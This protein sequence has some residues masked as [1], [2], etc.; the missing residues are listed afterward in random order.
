MKFSHQPVLLQETIEKLNLKPH[1]LY[2]DCT[3]GAAGH[4]MGMLAIEPT[5]RL[6]GIDQDPPQALERAQYRLAAY[7]RQVT[8]VRD[9]FR[10]LR[11]ILSGLHIGA[12]DGI[13]MDIGGVSSPQLDSAER[14]F[15]YQ[16]D[17]PLDMRMDPGQRLQ[18]ETIVNTYSEQQLAEIIRDYGEE[19][20][21]GRISE[22]IVSERKKSAA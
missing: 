6:I 10:N 1:A 13:L 20:W 7:A 9:N 3:L 15:S 12:V 19:R 17:A 18:A 11:D 22:F 4:S 8:L 16:Q 5:I 21:A 2:V 14:G